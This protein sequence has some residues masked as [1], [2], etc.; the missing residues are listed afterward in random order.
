MKI[1]FLARCYLDW[2]LYETV[3]LF[4]FSLFIVVVVFWSNLHKLN[5]QRN[6][7]SRKCFTEAV[8]PREK[9]HAPKAKKDQS[10][11]AFSSE[12]KNSKQAYMLSL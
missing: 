3:T 2:M 11:C 9:C 12:T 6:T 8:I 5:K 1:F 10:K 7:I 4:C